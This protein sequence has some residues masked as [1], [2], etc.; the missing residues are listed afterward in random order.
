[1]KNEGKSCLG[2]GEVL[3]KVSCFQEE[4]TGQIMDFLLTLYVKETP[5]IL[6]AILGCW[7]QMVWGRVLANWQEQ[8]REMK[9]TWF[10]SPGILPDSGLGA[11]LD[12]KSPYY[13]NQSLLELLAANG[14][15]TDAA[16]TISWVPLSSQSIITP[17][18]GTGQKTLTALRHHCGEL[19]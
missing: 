3:R 15:L 10:L 6:A 11:V 7:R 12:N 18:A 9:W 8:C 13:L 1:M 2:R 14:V 17:K 4:H 5:G 16:V 19:Q